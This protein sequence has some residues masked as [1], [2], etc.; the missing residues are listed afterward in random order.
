MIFSYWS[1]RKNFSVVLYPDWSN[2]CDFPS[3]PERASVTRG[4]HSEELGCAIKA[5]KLPSDLKV[6]RDVKFLAKAYDLPLLPPLP[7]CGTDEFKLFNRLSAD[8]ALKKGQ[9]SDFEVMAIK[10]RDFVNGK[11]IMTKL[12][13]YLV[14]IMKP[15]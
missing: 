8:T 13:V 5:I 6:S 9:E 14:Y 3:T 7:V 4:L 2:A 10:W 1:G 12:P 11:T 15:T